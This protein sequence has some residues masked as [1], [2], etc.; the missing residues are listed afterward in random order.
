MAVT[1]GRAAA[2]AAACAGAA[3]MFS[4]PSAV[5]APDP[6]AA[7]TIA[8]TVGS[9]GTN[10][11]VYLDAHPDTN[12][13]L[14]TIAGQPAGPQSVAALKLHFEAN[15][16]A[17]KDLQAIQQ[18]LTALTTKCQLPISLPQVLGLMQAAQQ[19]GLPDALPGAS[20]AAQAI[21]GTQ[22]PVAGAA[23]TAP[24]PKV[25]TPVGGGPLPGPGGR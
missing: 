6:C 8:R 21:S 14:T 20:A 1:T 12:E 23:K 11:G 2:L 10:T 13:A 17:A 3:A 19:N 25:V 16:Q 9:V 15:P 22:G 4:A 18:P 24:A 5:A 7:S